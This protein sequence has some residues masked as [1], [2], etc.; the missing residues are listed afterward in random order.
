MARELKLSLTPAFPFCSY[1]LILHI[2]L[3]TTFPNRHLSVYSLISCQ[4]VFHYSCTSRLKTFQAIYQQDSFDVLMQIAQ[5]QINLE[6][7]SHTE[8]RVYANI[9]VKCCFTF[10][11]FLST[12]CLNSPNCY[13]DCKN[14]PCKLNIG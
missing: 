14:K 10:K 6:R 9:Y 13:Y 4:D 8:K 11:H 12:F 1:D 7:S 3:H 5:L 2:H